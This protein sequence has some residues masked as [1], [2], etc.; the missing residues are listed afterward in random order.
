[1]EARKSH[2]A[3]NSSEEEDDALE[4]EAEQSTSQP[5]A[6]SA[7]FKTTAAR[8]TAGQ[9][10]K[11]SQGAVTVR[12]ARKTTSSADGGTRRPVNSTHTSRCF[13]PSNTTNQSTAKR[14]QSDQEDNLTTEKGGRSE[15]GSESEIDELQ[16]ELE[17]ELDSESEVSPPESKEEMVE[18]DTIHPLLAQGSHATAGWPV[19]I[20]SSA[21]ATHVSGTQYTDDAEQA[22]RQ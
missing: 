22:E 19:Q 4:N 7:H 2:A 12:A 15:H 3:A 9:P 17:L 10:V 6:R 13:S 14:T 11:Q 21:Q 1:M 20:D 8:K 5:P 18:E 16:Q